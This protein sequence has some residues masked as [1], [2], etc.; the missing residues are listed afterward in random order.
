MT[1]PQM[2]PIKTVQDPNAQAKN[3]VSNYLERPVLAFIDA[4]IVSGKDEIAREG[5]L[6]NL[7]RYR[8]RGVSPLWVNWLRQ[9]ADLRFVCTIHDFAEFND[10]ML[11]IVRNVEGVRETTTMLSFGGHIDIDTLLDLEMEVSPNSHTTVST[12]MIDVEAGRDR[13]CFQALLNLPPHPDVRRVWLLNCYH[14]DNAD[15]ML[16]LLGKNLSALTGYV[17]SWVRTT[18]GVIDTEM[19]T[20]LDW[21]W[22]ASPDD[23]VG[24]C[25]MFFKDQ[26]V[27]P[28]RR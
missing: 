22:M 10:F 20:V 19:S 17:M 11:D 8:T 18:P 7:S 12:V 14:S 24:L 15:L 23:I 27:T 4:D 25:E 26:R 28:E 5:L 9:R 2:I 3:T 21:R 16:M 13:E 6:N 1:K